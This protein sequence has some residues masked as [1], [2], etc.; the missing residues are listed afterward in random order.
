[1]ALSD[2]PGSWLPPH[3]STPSSVCTLFLMLSPACIKPDLEELYLRWVAS[4]GTES[5]FSAG[6]LW[7]ACHQECQLQWWQCC[8]CTCLWEIGLAPSGLLPRRLPNRRQKS[9]LVRLQ[10]SDLHCQSLEPAEPPQFLISNRFLFISYSQWLLPIDCT[11]LIKSWL[12][13]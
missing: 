13:L 12:L 6:S 8:V 4:S 7:Q 5:P 9:L 11:L 10:T 2:N 3:V 1:M